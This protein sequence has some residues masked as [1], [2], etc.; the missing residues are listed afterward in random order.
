MV[1]CCSWS[2]AAP[3]PASPRSRPGATS[4]RRCGVERRR[5]SSARTHDRHRLVPRRHVSRRRRGRT[6]RRARRQPA[7]GRRSRRDRRAVPRPG[8]RRPAERLER[9][10]W[11]PTPRC[12][13]AWPR[14]CPTR[15]RQGA[16]GDRAA[17]SDVCRR[18]RLR[19]HAR[20]RQRPVRRAGRGRRHR[21]RRLSRLVGS[22]SRDAD[23]ARGQRTSWPI[24][25]TTGWCRPPIC[26]SIAA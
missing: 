25:S 5:S 7:R 15:D 14:S 11:R 18:P 26:C 21:G 24:T 4:C 9:H 3:A 22:R 23:R 1:A 8:R 2:R 10:R 20:A 19:E 17:A 16:A 6:T 13:T 12:A